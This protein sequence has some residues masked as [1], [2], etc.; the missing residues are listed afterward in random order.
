M[1]EICYRIVEDFNILL[2]SS[3]EEFDED[4]RDF[5]GLIE[6]NFNGKKIGYMYEGEITD[7]MITVGCFQDEWMI[8]WFSN[9]LETVE[10]LRRSDYLILSE[11]ESPHWIEFFKQGDRLVVKELKEIQTFPVGF[12]SSCKPHISTEQLYEIITLESGKTYKRKVEFERCDFDIT[13]ILYSQFETEILRKS[14][15]FA[16][17]II[18][19]FPNLKS[20]TIINDFQMYIKKVEQLIYN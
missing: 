14:I 18:Y 8:L 13:N 12:E 4:I 17:E 3:K 2:D 9:L 5:E 6:L 11:I 16:N 7:E 20:S 10:Y 15:Q 1:F 19:L